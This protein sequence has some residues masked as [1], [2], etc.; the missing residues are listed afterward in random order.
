[1]CGKNEGELEISSPNYDDYSMWNVCKFCDKFIEEGQIKSM[2]M[3]L[4]LK[5][6]KNNKVQKEKKQ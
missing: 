3:Y 4:E 1:M 5:E 6:L 2:E